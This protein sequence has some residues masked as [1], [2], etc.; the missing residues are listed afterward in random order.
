MPDEEVTEDRLLGGAV[1]LLQPRRGHRAGT[2]AV[3]LAALAR[4]EPG[5]RVVDFG[6]ATG[7]VG[8]MAIHRQPSASV[9]L[10]E[11]EADLAALARHN[12]ELNGLL[13]QVRV[14]ESDV[15]GHG[16]ELDPG[17]ADVVLTN[18]PFFEGSAYRS[19]PDPG[20]RVA[21]VMAGG[22][23]AEW[24]QSAAKLLRARGRLCLIHRADA[25]PLCLGALAERFGSVE[26]RPIHAREGEPATRI[27]V[28]AVKGGRAPFRLLPPLVVHAPD[29]TFTLEAAA[30]HGS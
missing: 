4:I 20:R 16:G 7:A 3:L 6:A 27:L 18:P 22:G 19:S 17:S 2:D 25:L 11:K 12:V 5:D 28:A 10:L 15:F 21:H 1:R 30:L 29:G 13:E 24:L 14:V 9:I 23:L 26:L 8:L